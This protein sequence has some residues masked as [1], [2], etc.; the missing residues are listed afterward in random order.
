MHNNN[1]ICFLFGSG[2]SIP[3]HFPS[4]HEITERIL[5]GQNIFR[6]TDENYYLSESEVSFISRAENNIPLILL[7]FKNL[8]SYIDSYYIDYPSRITSYEDLFYLAVQIHDNIYGEYDNPA[9]KPFQDKV[10]A[11]FISSLNKKHKV[12]FALI[13]TESIK[14]IRC[15]VWQLLNKKSS[16]LDHLSFLKDALNDKNTNEIAICTLNHDI[17]I[18]ELMID[19]KEEFID[20][21]QKKNCSSIM[22]WNSNLF[23]GE[24]TKLKLIKLHG[25]VNWFRLRRDCG[26]RA[27]DVIAK[28]PLGQDIDH[29]YDHE[30]HLMSPESGLPILLIGR[31]NKIYSYPNTIFLDLHY[32]FMKS[33]TQSE[34][35]IISGYSFGDKGIN[36]QIA[37]WNS[38]KNN[39]FIILIDPKP[40]TVKI[41]ARPAIS[42]KWNDWITQGK[43]KII[44]KGIENVTW[45]EICH[46]FY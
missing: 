17:S 38:E 41:L 4:T 32:A 13:I 3:A 10:H 5:S 16:K 2:I 29:I 31:F 42:N 1:K 34:Q 8:K 45:E 7:L 11:E 37:K 9:V 40:A 23:E 18:E 25:S 22:Y 15:V 20:G 30:H 44:P 36:T 35:L 6:Y 39:R 28:I 43:L 14:Y 21:F 46:Y 33:L 26:T 27:D 19:S 24:S 12:D